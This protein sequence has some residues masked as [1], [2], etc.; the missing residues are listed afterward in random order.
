M[1]LPVV[2]LL[3]LLA[4][5]AVA[6]TATT[7]PVGFVSY[8][9]TQG[10]QYSGIPMVNAPSF[11]GMVAGISNTALTVS[12]TGL[13]LGAALTAGKAYYVEIVADPNNAGAY[14]GD[15]LDVDTAA[16]IA[17]ANATIV[18]KTSAEN[19]I[20]GNLPAALVGVKFVVRAH[21]TLAQVSSSS[22]GLFLAG[23]QIVIRVNGASNATITF[24]GTGWRQGITNADATV[25]YP[26]V[27]YL[28][29][30]ASATPSTGVFVGNV[31]TN[32]FAQ[33]IRAGE[34]ILAEGFPVDSAPHPTDVTV[35]SRLFTNDIGT[36][37][38]NGDRLFAYN[39]SNFTLFTYSTGTNR[40]AAGMT[41]GNTL[42][43]FNAT[44]A[45]LLKTAAANVNY[46]QIRPFPL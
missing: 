26:G 15:R 43:I 22:T 5:G 25:V 35:A 40:W 19:T 10:S 32:N 21:V 30:R 44:K 3:S 14:I 24:N 23:D 28:I 29:K 38:A 13:N 9:F 27:G 2:G 37:F 12:G 8:N 1:K 6:Q 42:K 18:I 36:T 11:S 46:I 7:D 4:V 34:Q 45:V 41:N 39:G 31:R 33:V 20:S 16:T 17:A